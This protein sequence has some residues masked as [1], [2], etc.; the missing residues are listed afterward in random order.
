MENIST[1]KDGLLLSVEDWPQEDADHGDEE[2]DG[3]GGREAADPGQ[4]TL[5]HVK[6]VWFSLNKIQ[7]LSVQPLT[8]K[9]V[10]GILEWILVSLLAHALVTTRSEPSA[11]DG[12]TL[13]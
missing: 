6:P 3:E 11:L 5:V 9:V 1:D 8:V 4:A 2:R 7:E 10:D 13:K 12:H